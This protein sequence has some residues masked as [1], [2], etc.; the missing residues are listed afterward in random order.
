MF[1]LMLVAQV[2]ALLQ[3]SPVLHSVQ[4]DEGYGETRDGCQHS[5][6]A[7]LKTNEVEKLAEQILIDID[8]LRLIV[9]A[10]RSASDKLDKLKQLAPMHELSK[11]GSR[12]I[13]DKYL[14]QARAYTLE[15]NRRATY[16]M[17]ELANQF[18]PGIGEGL[19]RELNAIEPSKNNKVRSLNAATL[20]VQ[21]KKDIRAKRLSSPLGNN[22]SQKIKLLAEIDPTHHYVKNGNRYIADAYIQ[23][24]LEYYW[25]NNFDR[26]RHFVEQA[27]KFEP[28]VGQGI[29]TRIELD[30]I[31]SESEGADNFILR[32]SVASS[33]DSTRISPSE[34][35][36]PSEEMVDI[37]ALEA[38]QGEFLDNGVQLENIEALAAQI[39]RDIR[40]KR[41]TSPLGDNAAQKIKLLAK[42]DPLHDYV[43]NGHRYIADAYI[44]IAL[45]YY[46]NNDFE[47]SRHFVEQARRFESGIGRRIMARME[48]DLAPAKSDRIAS[49]TSE[50]RVE[51]NTGSTTIPAS[52]IDLME[53]LPDVEKTDFAKPEIVSVLPVGN[54]IPKL[55]ESKLTELGDSVVS[56]ESETSKSPNPQFI[57][58]TNVGHAGSDQRNI[59]KVNSKLEA[60]LLSKFT[61]LNK[62]VESM[63]Q[64]ISKHSDFGKLGMAVVALLFFLFIPFLWRKTSVRDQSGRQN[65]TEVVESIREMQ[66]ETEYRRSDKGTNYS[67][68]NMKAPMVVGLCG[69]LFLILGVGAWSTLVE[70]SGAV[71]APGKLQVDTVKQ[72]I[73][74]PEDGVV[75]ELMVKNG[76]SVVEGDVLVR[77][78]DSKLVSELTIIEEEL[79]ELIV[80]DSRLKAERDRLTTLPIGSQLKEVLNSHPDKVK[81][82]LET[83]EKRLA[84][85]ALALSQQQKLISK[86]IEQ[87]EE[88]IKGVKS[89]VEA[90][91]LQLDSTR[92]ELAKALQAQRRGL[93]KA[94]VV[95]SLQKEETSSVG[96]IGR[97]NASI[98][99]LESKVTGH[100]L[101][102]IEIPL[103]RSEFAS[104][105]LG[106]Y[107]RGKKHLGRNE[108]IPWNCSQNWKY[109]RLLAVLFMT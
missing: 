16:R 73:Q 69:M 20:A 24:A 22:A 41:L 97:L 84:A 17:L 95:Y 103:K 90:R 68:M 5:P 49:F 66:S 52:H 106:S 54:P 89:Q 109:E 37:P 92:N 10:G 59:P 67:K 3:F 81:L 18:E 86:Q 57:V 42:I 71:I 87:V 72:L 56:S 77:M 44:Q 100:E 85:S 40:S 93:V 91:R 11:T 94:S 74:H 53:E 15:H 13:A 47:R 14:E 23:I 58:S 1:R 36:W 2:L 48:L 27:R 7:V 101:T 79:L 55:A 33:L 83:Q 35:E 104:I 51:G 78:D 19:E 8:A 80:E 6:E 50:V 38:Q 46:W 39:G 4:C 31:L 102:L 26:S 96:E 9:P 28:G 61:D 45:G 75:A 30:L 107:R 76:D 34:K 65:D 88:Q 62:F 99:E 12:K 63:L 29:I 108:E 64:K 70:I 60:D 105:E 43:K 82:I 25:N 32:E 98:S 21:I